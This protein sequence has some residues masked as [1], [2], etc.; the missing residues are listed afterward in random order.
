M[1][2]L[3]VT[4]VILNGHSLR[5][6]HFVSKRVKTLLNVNSQNLHTATGLPARNYCWNTDLP[7][8]T[9]INIDNRVTRKTLQDS[10]IPVLNCE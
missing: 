6:N 10:G 2:T 3:L 5:V 7:K 4:I 9:F 8:G 1:Q